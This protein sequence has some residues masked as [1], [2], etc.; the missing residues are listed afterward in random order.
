MEETTVVK[1]KIFVVYDEFGEIRATAAS[2]HLEAAV[3]ATRG[4]HVHEVEHPGNE[5]AELKRH[6][7]DLH[8]QHRVDLKERKLVRK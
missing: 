3:R 2:A 8:R 6:L 4:H 1:G 7:L 5:G